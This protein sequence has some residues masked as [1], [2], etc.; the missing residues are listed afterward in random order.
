MDDPLNVLILEDNPADAELAAE[1]LRKAGLSIQWQRVQTERDYLAALHSKLDIILADHSLPQY[2]SV[3]A[4]DALKQRNLDV[5]F[6]VV[7]G[8]IDEELAV[9]LM[10]RG[11]ADYVIKDRLARLGQAVA[12]ALQERKVRL[13]KRQAEQSLVLFRALLDR[14]NDAIEIIDPA[15]GRFLDVN[16]RACTTYGYTRAE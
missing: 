15:T 9:M 2:D 10:K 8:S 11:A 16:D 6:V 7:S 3:R 5:P 1:E 12:H 4:L 13:E 14:T